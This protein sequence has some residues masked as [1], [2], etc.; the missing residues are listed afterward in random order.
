MLLLSKNQLKESNLSRTVYP[1]PNL[2]ILREGVGLSREKLAR[3]IDVSSATIQHWEQGN[4]P[5]ASDKLFQLA[6]FFKCSPEYLYGLTDVENDCAALSGDYVV[7][8]K[9]SLT[10]SEELLASGR[11]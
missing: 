3:V 5:I 6:E 11:S 10:G 1:K 8:K 2:R 9:D 7:V 4:R